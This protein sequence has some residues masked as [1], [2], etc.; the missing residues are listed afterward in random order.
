MNNNMIAAKMATA[1]WFA[2]VDT[3]TI[4]IYHPTSSKF[5]LHTTDRQTVNLDFFYQ[6]LA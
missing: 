6:T 5:D 2:F 1:S 3:L 4:V